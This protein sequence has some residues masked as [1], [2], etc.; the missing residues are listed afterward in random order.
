MKVRKF[1]KHFSRAVHNHSGA[2]HKLKVQVIPDCDG[3]LEILC[4]FCG[5]SLMMGSPGLVNDIVSQLSES[6]YRVY[7]ENSPTIS[8]RV[9]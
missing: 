3:D 2:G 8:L 1:W 4:Q 9:H 6:G 7:R 5:V